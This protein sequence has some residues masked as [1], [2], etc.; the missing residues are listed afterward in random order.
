MRRIALLALGLAAPALCCS[1]CGGAS[2]QT[3]SVRV[4]AS[5]SV[6][7]EQEYESEHECEYEREHEWEYEETGCC[8]G[9]HEVSREVEWRWHRTPA[10]RSVLRY[11][12]VHYGPSRVRCRVGPWR[13]KVT[14]CSP[15]CRVHH[16]HH[17][18]RDCG[19]R[20]THV[21]H[22][23]PPPGH[24][25]YRTRGHVH[26]RTTHVHH[27]VHRG[28]A[29]GHHKVHV[30]KTTKHRSCTP[31]GREPVGRRPLRR[32]PGVH[33]ANLRAEASSSGRAKK[34]EVVTIGRTG[35]VSVSTGPRKQLQR[36]EVRRW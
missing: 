5:A 14:V 3:G 24:P 32:V 27:H 30:K 12:T 16:V 6:S 25:H 35:T 10:G 7:W 21:R 13:V 2:G 11:R 8:G 1:E 15:G 4:S 34:S 36:R 23:R 20:C 18:R 19:P 22:H 33:R 9:T 17:Y 31:A 28:R 29:R 26:K